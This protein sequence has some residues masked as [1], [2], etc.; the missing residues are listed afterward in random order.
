[1]Q[2]MYLWFAAH[3]KPRIGAEQQHLEKE[4][5]QWL[6]EWGGTLE[7]AFVDRTNDEKLMEFMFPNSSFLSVW[8]F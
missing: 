2:S 3:C 7:K 8:E 5:S 6:A 1:M 4:L